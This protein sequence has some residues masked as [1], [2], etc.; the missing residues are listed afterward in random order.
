MVNW[1]TPLTWGLQFV[2]ASA[3]GIVEVE[4]T[5]DHANCPVL[6]TFVNTLYEST[7]YIDKTGTYSIGLLTGSPEAGVIK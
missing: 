7:K 4:G 2:G 6:I 3:D 5:P 1:V